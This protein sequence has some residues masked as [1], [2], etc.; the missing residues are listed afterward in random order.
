MKKPVGRPPLD[1]TGSDNAS[2]V[3]L[4][5]G[6]GSAM[7][8]SYELKKSSNSLMEKAGPR[9][10]SEPSHLN[11]GSSENHNS[12]WSSHQKQDRN[13]DFTGYKLQ[14]FLKKMFYTLYFLLLRIVCPLTLPGSYLRGGSYKQGKKSVA[15][16]ETRRDTYI[17]LHPSTAVNNN[18]FSTFDIEKK[19]LLPV[20]IT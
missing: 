9:D 12:G 17:Q 15:S 20:S 14:H 10:S 7:W 13:Y 4:A 2:G 1:R 6:K 16:S 3:T 19:M 11:L 18:V 8:S 5:T